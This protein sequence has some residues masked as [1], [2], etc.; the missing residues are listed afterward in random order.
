MFSDHWFE[1]D[2]V[3]ISICEKLTVEENSS[4]RASWT[5]AKIR[6]EARVDA[7]GKKQ[8]FLGDLKINQV[9]NNKQI[10]CQKCVQI[11]SWSLH[12]LIES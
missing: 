12:A 10:L 1:I 2:Q 9:V 4:N 8:T 6:I 11:P 5:F 3:Q 7:K